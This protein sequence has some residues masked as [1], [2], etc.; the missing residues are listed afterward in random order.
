MFLAVSV[1]FGV[2]SCLAGL[3]MVCLLACL[4]GRLLYLTVCLFVYLPDWSF[5]V[6]LLL[7]LWAVIDPMPSSVLWLFG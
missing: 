2:G 3:R 5:Y 7:F 6:C 4:I 1:L